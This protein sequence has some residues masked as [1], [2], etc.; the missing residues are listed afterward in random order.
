MAVACA[1]VDVG[2]ANV[3]RA[4]ETAEA[5]AAK[6]RGQLDTGRDETTMNC[7]KCDTE[8][9]FAVEGT[10]IVAFCPKCEPFRKSNFVWSE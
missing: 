4:T 9:V 5:E 2:L 10:D 3:M 8:M 6:V 1:L 7:P